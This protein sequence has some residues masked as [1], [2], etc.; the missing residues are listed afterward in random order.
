MSGAWEGQ[1]YIPRTLDVYSREAIDSNWAQGVRIEYALTTGQTAE[2]PVRLTHASWLR[3]EYDPRGVLN[4]LSTLENMLKQQIEDTKNELKEMIEGMER[5]TAVVDR[6]IILT[7]QNCT[8]L[9][10]DWENYEAIDGRFPLAAGVAKGASDDI[11]KFELLN[12]G[13][14]YLHQLTVDEMPTHNHDAGEGKYLVQRVGYN[15]ETGVDSIENTIDIRTG[16]RIKEAGGGLPHNNIPPY[17]V[18]NFCHKP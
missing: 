2:F 18:M 16:F 15:T 1:Q 8:D 4:A 12:S 6:S 10:E 9:G 17:L 5:S 11:G 3:G 13:G 14:E 7:D